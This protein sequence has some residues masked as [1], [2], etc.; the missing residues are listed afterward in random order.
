MIM[1]PRLQIVGQQPNDVKVLSSSTWSGPKLQTARHRETASLCIRILAVPPTMALQRNAVQI[2]SFP[3]L[4]LDEAINL[5]N[6]E[7]IMY[8]TADI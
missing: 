3:C 5:K 2:C 8:A 6:S 7:S 1:T 4:S